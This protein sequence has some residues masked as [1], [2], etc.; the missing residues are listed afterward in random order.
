MNAKGLIKSWMFLL[1]I[2]LGHSNL[3]SQS[4]KPT[5]TGE[6]VKHKYYTLSYIEEHEQ[7]EWVHYLLT[8]DMIEGVAKRKCKI[9]L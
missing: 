8:R 2:V 1:G 6:L 4:Y 7:A 3:Y 9:R 5:N